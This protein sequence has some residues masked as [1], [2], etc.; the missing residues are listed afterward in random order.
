MKNIPDSM[1]V[2]LNIN[3]D[4]IGQTLIKDDSDDYLNMQYTKKYENFEQIF[5]KQNELNNFN[6]DIRY[7]PDEQ[8]RGASDFMSF[9]AEGIPVISL[10]TGLHR[11]YHFPNDELEFIDLEKMTNIIKLTYLGLNDILETE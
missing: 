1:N 11:D 9:A 6:L 2:V 8:P 5:Q 3:L 7:Q 10:F 4:M